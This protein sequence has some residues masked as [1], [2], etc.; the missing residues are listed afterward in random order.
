[1]F[2][3]FSVLF[4]SKTFVGYIKSNKKNTARLPH[5]KNG[6]LT[7]KNLTK[8]NNDLITSKLDII[9]ARDYKLSKDI[10][11]IFKYWRNL[12]Q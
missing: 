10:S 11:V 1:M 7:L 6:I 9:Y 12:D 5:L 8:K 3:L 2:N 4:G